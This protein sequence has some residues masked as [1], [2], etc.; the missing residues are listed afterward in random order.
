MAEP[1]AECNRDEI[2]RAMERWFPPQ[3]FSRFSAEPGWSAQ[4]LFWMAALMGWVAGHT[5]T[6]RFRAARDVLRTLKPRWR[7]PT[8]LSGYNAAW[9]RAEPELLDAVVARLREQVRELNLP[10]VLGWQLFAVDGSRFECPRTKANERVLGCAGKEHTTPQLF[11]TTL[12]HLGSELPWDFRLGP[13]TDSERRHL[14]AMLSTLPAGS[15]LTADAGFISY[16]L[17]A[18]LRHRRVHFVLRVGGNITL[19]TEL[20][21]THEVVGET[22]YLWPT[23][24][25]NQPPIRLR[26]IKITTG[27]THVYLLT[28]ILDPV[29]LSDADAA[30]IYRRRWG[31]EVYYRTVKRTF[32][33]AKLHSRTPDHVAIEQ[34]ALLIS[35]WLLQLTSVA[36]RQ[37]ADLPPRRWSGATARLRIREW[38]RAVL[39]GHSTRR[40]SPLNHQLANAVTDSYKRAGPKQR[41]HWPRKKSESPPSPP[42]QRP[43]TELER[44]KANRLWNQT[45][46][47][48]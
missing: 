21:G 39:L 14:D 23:K 33:F 40:Q 4:K 34:R 5:L 7:I 19:L 27:K 2:V 38:L 48:L 36:A 25:Q 43:A 1:Q 35:L 42:K 32:P 45:Q 16:E 12:W 37:E 3:W 6:E 20:G 18:E 8:S 28:D 15:L 44:Q 30:E 13:G 41:R 29:Q 9:L 47:K 26:L 46:L 24:R 17:C 22:V 11:Q 31:G 10:P